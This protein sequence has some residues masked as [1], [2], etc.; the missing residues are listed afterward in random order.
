M[1]TGGGRQD[2][3]FEGLPEDQSFTLTL[4]PPTK[5]GYSPGLE[6]GASGT[7]AMTSP[8]PDSDLPPPA[9]TPELGRHWTAPA[10]T[11]FR[12]GEAGAFMNWPLKLSADTGGGGPNAGA[13][14][15]KH[16]GPR[17]WNGTLPDRADSLDSA[18]GWE[19]I[20]E[21]AKWRDASRVQYLYY[22][23]VM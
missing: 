9:S 16:G 18:A 22:A 8:T 2:A 13:G 12:Q 23:G 11:A 5:F 14:G 3:D 4:E 21:G 1:V 19:K 20:L 7:T 17:P 10:P 6:L 15:N